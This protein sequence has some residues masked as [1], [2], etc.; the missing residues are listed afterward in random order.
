MINLTANAL[1]ADSCSTH[2]FSWNWKLS[3]LPAPGPNT[4]FSCFS[5]GGGST[6]GYKL[7]GFNVVGNVEIDKKIIEMYKKNHHPKYSYLLDIRDFL[8]IPDA[9]IPEELFNL[10]V[11]DGSPPCSVFSEAGM[12]E[13]AWGVEKKFREGQKAQTLDDLFFYFIAVA[14]RLRPKIVVAEN[15]R[16]LLKGNAKGYVS[17]ILKQFSDAGYETQL[18]LLNASTMGVPQKRE[19][20]FFIARRK[21]LF[22]QSLSLSFNEPPIVFGS[23][24]TECGLPVTDLASA[25]LADVRPDE[26]KL[27]YAYRR[28]FGKE[29]FFTHYVLDDNKVANTLVS[30]GGIYR[31]FDKKKCSDGDFIAMQTFPQDYDFCGNSVQYVCG[32][33]VP[34][35]MMA[36]IASEIKRQWL[37]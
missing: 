31:R 5:C 25:L 26:N 17:E 30:N 23:I 12:R 18:F 14:K 11:L 22:L 32:M 29:A 27:S 16:G 6:M 3:D 36:Q 33:S 2:K 35:V 10:D 37:G 8:K 13:K 4:V 20:C 19:R 15:V 1:D 7:A 21:D 28:R 24:R 9:E 34:P